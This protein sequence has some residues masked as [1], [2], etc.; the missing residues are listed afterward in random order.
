[1]IH[2]TTNVIPQDG[3]IPAHTE[4]LACVLENNLKFD[5]MVHNHALL[6]PPSGPM[7]TVEKR[8]QVRD[9]ALKCIEYLKR[10]ELLCE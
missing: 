8:M 3:T 2:L 10:I 4:V 7:Y 6:G 9:A 5:N 1:M